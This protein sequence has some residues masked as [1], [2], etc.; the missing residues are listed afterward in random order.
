MS[1]VGS[2]AV[3]SCLCWCREAGI[4]LGIGICDNSARRPSC[5]E[6]GLERPS[7]AF[8]EQTLSLEVHSCEGPRQRGCGMVQRLGTHSVETEV[9]HLVFC[10]KASI[11]R[12]GN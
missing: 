4:G 11:R 8:V 7:L 3:S 6:Y 1:K 2:E 5:S 10:W 9:M 12:Q